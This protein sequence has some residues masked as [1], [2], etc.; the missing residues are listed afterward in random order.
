MKPAKLVAAV[1]EATLQIENSV[2]WSEIITRLQTAGYSPKQAHQLRGQVWLARK[3][4]KA[5]IS[6]Q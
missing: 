4:R 2:A 1:A 3:V 5:S 6:V